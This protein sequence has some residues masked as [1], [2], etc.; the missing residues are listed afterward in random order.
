MSKFY[1]PEKQKSI[2]FGLNKAKIISVTDNTDLAVEDL[3][4]TFEIGFEGTDWT[5]DYRQSFKFERNPDGT[6]KE[7]DK[8]LK[9]FY[10]TFMDHLNLEKPIGL[11][12]KGTFIYEDGTEV[13]DIEMAIQTQLHE[14]FDYIAYIEPNNYKGKTYQRV[15]YLVDAT[16]PEILEDMERL[17]KWIKEN[18]QDSVA[19][20]EV[21]YNEQELPS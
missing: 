13:E 18:S 21:E 1:R 8:H 15:R 14:G 5:R 9:R 2:K 3:S 17:L 20:H 11:D 10:N 12:E 6:I 19:S 7:N 4:L 16:D